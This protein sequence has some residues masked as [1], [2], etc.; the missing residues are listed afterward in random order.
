MTPALLDANV[1]IALSVEDHEHHRRAR[2]W[3][4][5]SRPFATTPTTQGALA[6]FL[7][8]VATADHALAALQMLQRNDRHHFWH[9]DRA[10]DFDVL[11]G[12]YSH[13]QVTDVYLAAIAA[14]HQSVLATFDRAIAALRPRD[15]EL[16]KD[17]SR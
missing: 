8:R 6:R 9:D 2:R 16:I 12:V 14:D 1:L 11:R 13:R 17:S 15:V 5:S 7:V 4:G 10:F 3:L